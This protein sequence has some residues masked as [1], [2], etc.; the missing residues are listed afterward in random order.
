MSA[1]EQCVT[2]EMV[3]TELDQEECVP[4]EQIREQARKEKLEPKTGHETESLPVEFH[5]R[6]A[7]QKAL[8]NLESAKTHFDASKLRISFN[9]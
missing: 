6:T 4:I 3:I 9:R 8:A 2:C 1:V 7:Q 5:D